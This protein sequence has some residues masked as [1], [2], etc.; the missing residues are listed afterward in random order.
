MKYIIPIEGE[1]TTDNP[2][3]PRFFDE[4]PPCIH[5]D[6]VKMVCEFDPDEA[7]KTIEKMNL[8]KDTASILKRKIRIA[9]NKLSKL[10]EEGK[11]LVEEG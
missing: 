9:A 7:I 11:V 1:G 8:D 3:K 4:A 6:L 2:F 5:Y 10:A